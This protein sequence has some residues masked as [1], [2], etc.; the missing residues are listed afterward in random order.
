[1][2]IVEAII[3]ADLPNKVLNLITSGHQE[4]LLELKELFLHILGESDLEVGG[5]RDEQE[6]LV[7]AGGGRQSDELEHRVE[8]VVDLLLE[9]HTVLVVDD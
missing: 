1:M 7:E 4:C 6:L 2:I 9:T 8:A 3:L 5:F